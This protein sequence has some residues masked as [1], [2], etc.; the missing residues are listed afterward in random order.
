MATLSLELGQQLSDIGCEQ[1]G[2]THK[3]A[4]GF[5][6]RSG[7]AFGLYF[8][9]LHTGHAEP[10]VGTLSVGKWWDDEAVDE[11]NWVFLRVWSEANEYR[12]G[13]LDPTLS[14]H[15]NY[16]ALGNP[17]DREAALG[18][19]LR[20]TFLKSPNSLSKMTRR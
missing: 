2:G 8:A 19:V 4:Y 11:R 7:D 20:M 10:S 12:M 5:V 3:S 6:Y 1:C 13:L 15:R 16:K 18:S 9:T 17:L 14:Q